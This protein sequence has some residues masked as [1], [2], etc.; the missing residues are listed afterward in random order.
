MVG[1]CSR[2]WEQH[3]P[4]QSHNS[5]VSVLCVCTEPCALGGIGGHK[6]GEMGRAGVGPKFRLYLEGNGKT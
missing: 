4:R 2:K 3:V 1:G 6:A 5:M